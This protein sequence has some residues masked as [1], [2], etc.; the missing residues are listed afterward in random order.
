MATT[1]NQI[2]TYNVHYETVNVYTVTR[3]KLYINHSFWWTQSGKSG[4]RTKIKGRIQHTSSFWSIFI[5]SI[6]F[7]TRTY[8]SSHC[9]YFYIY[10]YIYTISYKHLFTV[11]CLL[12]LLGY[13]HILPS[14]K[15]FHDRRNNQ[16]WVIWCTPHLV[17]LSGGGLTISKHCII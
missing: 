15:E 2:T 7:H 6:V 16:V 11:S 5:C 17:G 4:S 10:I 9:I 3:E 13:V 12:F 14:I 1:A 8:Y